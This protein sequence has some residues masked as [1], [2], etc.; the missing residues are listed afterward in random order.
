MVKYMSL[1]EALS[2]QTSTVS[3]M[4][5]FV[6]CEF[7]SLLDHNPANVDGAVHLSVLDCFYLD[8]V[9][10]LNYL[11]QM[12]CGFLSEVSMNIFISVLSLN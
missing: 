10:H 3:D 1:W 5:N 4:P 11:T 9:E 6:S 2:I 8:P 7:L 12:R